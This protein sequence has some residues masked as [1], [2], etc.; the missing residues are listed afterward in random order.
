MANQF[1]NEEGKAIDRTSK[2]ESDKY[3]NGGSLSVGEENENR[4]ATNDERGDFYGTEGMLA[5]IVDERVEGSFTS[6]NQAADWAHS[7]KFAKGYRTDLGAFMN[8]KTN[9]AVK[10]LGQLMTDRMQSSMSKENVNKYGYVGLAY[11]SNVNP[12]RSY[13]SGANPSDL[14]IVELPE[15]VD[16]SDLSYSDNIYNMIGKTNGLKTPITRD[17]LLNSVTKNSFKN[18]LRLG[19]AKVLNPDF[20]F[21]ELDDVRSDIREYELGRLYGERIYDYN[22]PILYLNPGTVKINTSLISDLN[23]FQHGNKIGSYLKDGNGIGGGIFNVAF[24]IINGL[25]T[26]VNWVLSKGMWYDFEYNFKQ[27]SNYVNE[28]LIELAMWMGLFDNNTFTHA[29]GDKIN[30]LTTLFSNSAEGSASEYFNNF[31][32]SDIGEVDSAELNEDGTTAFNGYI[33]GQER[34]SVHYILP[35]LYSNVNKSEDGKKAT[36]TILS[37]K[38]DKSFN[39]DLTRM[40][41][42]YALSKSISVSENFNNTV[43]THPIMTELNSMYETSNEVKM[44]GSWGAL[45]NATDAASNTNMLSKIVNKD[46]SGIMGDVASGAFSAVKSSLGGLGSL[47]GVS[48]ALFNSEA[49]MIIKGEGRFMMPKVWSDST[50]SRNYSINMKFRSP[51]GDRVSIFENTFIPLLFLI[52][53]TSPRQ[54]GFSSYTTPYYVKAYSKGL[55]SCELGMIS[56]LSITRG[57]DRNDRTIE[58]FFRT[59]SVSLTIEDVMPTMSM[60]MSA[61][62]FAPLKSTNVGLKNYLTGLAGIDFI[63][64]EAFAHKLD[65]VPKL[66][67]SKTAGLGTSVMAAFLNK[68]PGGKRLSYIATGA[69]LVKN[70]YDTANMFHSSY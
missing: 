34:L 69:G 13:T 35:S 43:D 21:N 56:S 52:G 27:Y 36:S 32:N 61:G 6:L 47:F 48:G 54:A 30:K 24:N 42:P 55:I 45:K 70:D 40:T 60:S 7:D 53:L 20:Q 51:Y 2:N 28:M 41:I 37:G 62:V 26:G 18:G 44:R 12:N 33:G 58:G 4:D 22:L 68:T 39:V 5:A 25:K 10:D 63:E 15:G 19:E 8:F 29:I 38:D 3:A 16:G 23:S 65:V 49:G 11:T 59:I 67:S 17:S 9:I 46:F 50:Y 1:Y 57:E 14:Y 66:L 64:R 31:D